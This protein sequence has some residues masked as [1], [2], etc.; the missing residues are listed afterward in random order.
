MTAAFCHNVAVLRKARG[1][2]PGLVG[3]GAFAVGVLLTFNYT[4]DD[5]LITLRYASNLLHGHGPVFNIGERVEG[6]SSPLH[7]IAAT[8]AL[9]VPGGH[10]LLK[11]K[12]LS[13]AAG[14]LTIVV[15]DMLARRLGLGVP[16]RVAA[17]GLIGASC[18]FATSAGNGLETS[19]TA[20]LVT[21]LTAS[22][23]G[24]RAPGWRSAAAL[25]AALLVMCRPEGIGIV[26]A[27]AAASMLL[28][29]GRRLT[30]LAWVAP[31][32]GAVL[33]STLFRIAYYREPVANTFYA[34]RVGLRVAMHNARI[35]LLSVTGN[36]WSHS[37]GLLAAAIVGVAC[38]ALLAAALV[39]RSDAIVAAAAIG[40]QV[41][42]VI[43]AGGDW[44]PGGRFVA[45]V[46]P[47]LVVVLAVGTVAVRRR[48]GR[49]VG[50]AI[51]G[52]AAL[53]A[54]AATALPYRTQRSPA[55]Q[56]AGFSDPALIASSPIPLAPVWDLV[57]REPC[58][59]PGMTVAYSEV[60]LFGYV[61]RDV[62]IVDTRGLT[63]RVIARKSPTSL[64]HAWGVEDPNW[65][66]TSSVVGA[67]LVDVHP[68]LIVAF[69]Y[70]PV[71]QALDGR[72]VLVREEQG[73]GDQK[74]QILRRLDVSCPV[75]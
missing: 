11:L 40:A 42:F 50:G 15:A 54:A 21:A 55:W 52:V 44:M 12:L 30:A 8:L 25:H 74:V 27:I 43:A 46:L 51:V 16:G 17:C 45:P 47:D 38:V 72:Y 9:L 28:P 71:G 57:A 2:L 70:Q 14:A 39:A 67:R 49:L 56:L 65:R 6:F 26:V 58:V 73:V 10:A 75:G 53:T 3:L 35:Y 31:A 4:A 41:A 23:V 66:A 48:T 29:W 62:R 33:V 34:K 7:L 60:G 20:L 61:H 59:R 24:V 19:L 18:I 36:A 1:G 68:D 32:V 69:D 13:V 37:H 22:L 5:P 63:D 64:H